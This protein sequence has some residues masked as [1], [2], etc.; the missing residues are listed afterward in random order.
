MRIMNNY[1]N[2]MIS[3]E[4]VIAVLLRLAEQIAADRKHSESMGISEE[5]MAFMTR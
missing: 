2:D 3:N 4:E 5:E 1:L